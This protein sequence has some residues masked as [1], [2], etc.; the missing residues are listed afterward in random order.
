MTNRI[1]ERERTCERPVLL[2]KSHRIHLFS[3]WYAQEN[4]RLEEKWIFRAMDISDEFEIS[5][6]LQST[7]I[8]PYQVHIDWRYPTDDSR[9]RSLRHCSEMFSLFS[10]SLPRRD[11]LVP[12]NHTRSVTDLVVDAFGIG[13]DRQTW[14]ILML[15]YRSERVG[16][17][18]MDE[19]GKDLRMRRGRIKHRSQILMN[20]VFELN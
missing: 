8:E 2:H 19:A 18:W 9:L 5:A 17:C 3:D 11:V 16:G 10:P 6:G 7:S 1:R 4:E 13:H 20:K 14:C 12:T 15:S